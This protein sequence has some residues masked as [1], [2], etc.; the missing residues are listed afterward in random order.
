M[1]TTQVISGW[2]NRSDVDRLTNDIDVDAL[3]AVVVPVLV[4]GLVG[5]RARRKRGF[6]LEG[7]AFLGVVERP[8]GRSLLA[9]ECIGVDGTVEGSV[10]S[11]CLTM[12][13][14]VHFAQVKSST[15]QCNGRRFLHDI[16]AINILFSG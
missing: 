2:R 10:G 7:C 4:D 1:S 5:V 14:N 6:E 15:V 11:T 13:T 16:E 9:F 3:A 8:F 12:Q